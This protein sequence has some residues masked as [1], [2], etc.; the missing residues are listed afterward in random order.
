M[1][2][3]ESRAESFSAPCASPSFE[4]KQR[5]ETKRNLDLLVPEFPE[6][7]DTGRS[8]PRIL[9]VGV[10]EDSHVTCHE[11]RLDPFLQVSAPVNDGLVP[12]LRLLVD[13]FAV[14][15]PANSGEV[16]SNGNYFFQH[17]TD[18][19]RPHLIYKSKGNLVFPELLSEAG[20]E[21]VFIAYGD[22]ELIALRKHLQKERQAR[23][24]F[25]NAF[26]SPSAL[27]RPFRRRIYVSEICRLPGGVGWR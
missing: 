12:G 5:R 9:V 11:Q 1:P 4:E 15:E 27:G 22:A 6:Q 17:V 20:I 18:A 3:T 7:S 26:A 16:C 23:E 19:R 14:A 24:K 13:A 10:G 8:V 25:P 21:P 2:S